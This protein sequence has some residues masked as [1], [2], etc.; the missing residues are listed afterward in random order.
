MPTVPQKGQAVRRSVSGVRFFRT[1]NASK[2][3]HRVTHILERPHFPA[4]RPSF[5][6]LS[7]SHEARSGLAAVSVAIDPAPFRRVLPLPRAAAAHLRRAGPHGPVGDRQ[8]LL[9][10]AAGQPRLT[11]IEKIPGHGHALIIDSGWREVAGKAL[12]FV[13]RSPSVLASIPTGCRYPVRPPPRAG[14]PGAAPPLRSGTGFAGQR[15]S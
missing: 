3:G 10:A 6:G 13:Q 15:R 7:A 9:Q 1:R 5:R 14:M 4:R 11:E 2:P 12:A 8:R